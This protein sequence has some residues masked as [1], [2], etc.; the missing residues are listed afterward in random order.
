M[1][2]LGVAVPVASMTMRL[3]TVSPPIR[4][5]DEYY[6]QHQHQG[7]RTAVCWQRIVVLK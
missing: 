3:L 4:I 6:Y 7:Q 5:V 1:V 2:V